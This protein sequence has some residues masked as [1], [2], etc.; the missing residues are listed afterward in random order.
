MP[1]LLEKYHKI[2]RAKYIEILLFIFPDQL[3]Q[4]ISNRIREITKM[5]NN[6]NTRFLREKL[7][8][9]G[10][11]SRVVKDKYNVKYCYNHTEFNHSPKLSKLQKN[12]NL[13]YQVSPTTLKSQARPSE[14]K[15]KIKPCI[16]FLFPTLSFFLLFTLCLFSLA[17]LTAFALC[18]FIGSKTV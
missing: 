16:F 12:T 7:L 1:M 8:N 17:H 5:K 13:K 2:S 10:E 3:L 4:K 11:K 6:N 15:I 9:I 18:L 14:Y